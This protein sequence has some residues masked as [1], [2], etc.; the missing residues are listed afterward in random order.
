M[1]GFAGFITTKN[2]DSEKI[3]KQM[4]QKIHHR[5]PND[6]GF[7]LDESNG[8]C[9]GHKRLSI[10]DLSPLGHQPMFSD[11]NRYVIVFNGEIYNFQKLTQ[12]LNY[13]FKSHSDTEVLLAMI[14]LWGLDKA[15]KESVGMFAFALWDKQTKTL[16]LARDRMGE[17]PLYYGFQ[18]DSLLFGSDLSALKQHPDFIGEIDK[19]ALAS[20][21]RY[22]YVPTPHSIYKNIKKLPA[23]HY[24]QYQEG[25]EKLVEYWSIEESYRLGQQNLITDE[26]QAKQ[27]LKDL[28]QQ[29][30]AEQK[31]ADVP[32]G[33]FLSGG[34]DS[35][36]ISALMQ[37]QSG[38]KIDTFTIGFEN[39][40]Y[41]EANHA[42]AV[43]KHL[44]TNHHELILTPQNCLDIVPKLSNIYSEP[45]ADSSQ[46][47]TFL[48]SQLAKKNVSV[49]LSGDGADELFCGYNRYQFV[50]KVWHK[51]KKLSPLQRRLL[52]KILNFIPAKTVALV[53]NQPNLTDKLFKL[54]N[55][56]DSNSYNDLYQNL[57][58][59]WQ[60]NI[61][62][63]GK[64]E[65]F[66]KVNTVTQMMLS[67]QQHY[68]IDDILTKVD[69]AAMA[70][71]LETRVPF[72]DYQIV[73]FSH[74]IPLS[75]HRKNN[76]S[77]YLLRQILYDF[78]PKN[79]IERPKMGFAVPIEHWLRN[80]L[81]DWAED[82]LQ[83]QKLEQYFYSKPILEKWQ[84]H[85]SGKRNWQYQLWNVLSFMSWMENQN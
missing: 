5:G 1:C 7:F 3:I 15:L 13:S 64:S 59:Q 36:L 6:D 32:T 58:T 56:I 16:T 18:K 39:K 43:A 33:A 61:V 82:L 41:N 68:L 74:Q 38:K 30:V 12:Q 55:V 53:I 85:L 79:L 66:S 40:N 65:H 27:Q 51:I 69:R 20:F 75:L 11:N 17:K 45:F 63:N 46:I 80:E 4:L 60:E 71:S 23:G 57:T 22:S 44:N 72:L 26:K 25:A 83:K 67:D 47:P 24:Y 77:K 54:A 14:S 62:K 10:Q 48:V 73:E 35:S 19:D 37:Q 42:K 34:I 2:N 9:L 70:V 28:L 78:V 50:P 84:Q 81:R 52:A 31:I 76:Q 8:L 49:A 29:S 21:M